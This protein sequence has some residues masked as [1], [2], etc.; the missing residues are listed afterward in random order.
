MT[1]MKQHTW[2]LVGVGASGS[3]WQTYLAAKSSQAENLGISLKLWHEHVIITSYHCS[4]DKKVELQEEK[5]KQ[6]TVADAEDEHVN[7]VKESD[8][9]DAM[10]ASIEL[11][12]CVPK[13]GAALLPVFFL[14]GLDCE[15]NSLH[16]EREQQSC[17]YAKGQKTWEKETKGYSRQMTSLDL[18]TC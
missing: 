7:D 3:F 11:E 16:S 6:Y 17:R 15:S 5:W 18:L 10:G 1:G 14:G 4:F 2:F 8:V 13:A 12:K 9:R